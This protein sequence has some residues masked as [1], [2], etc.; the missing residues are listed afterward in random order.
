MTWPVRSKLLGRH[1]ASATGGTF[2]SLGTVPTG[3]TWIIKDWRIYN[4]AGGSIDINLYSKRA[5]VRGVIDR[6]AA[7]AGDSINGKT[8][9]LVVM[10]AGDELEFI[11]S[12]TK[13]ISLHVSGAQLG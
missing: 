5:G 13:V 12:A 2:Y 9:I 11:V 8:G 10:A 7:V 6:L 1:V 4:A 3:K